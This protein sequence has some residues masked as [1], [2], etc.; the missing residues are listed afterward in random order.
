MND[1][2]L[3][4]VNDLVALSGD[5]NAARTAAEM[6]EIGLLRAKLAAAEADERLATALVTAQAA[7]PATCTNETQR[8]A[9]AIAATAEQAV[10]ASQCR[11]AQVE[12][13]CARVT[14]QAALRRVEDQR[15]TLE[16]VVA[17][18]G[19]APE[20]IPALP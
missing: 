1:N 13:E 12:A 8:R 17:V 2:K 11:A 16:Q 14:A 10:A 15:R 6:A 9:Y 18:A 19:L 20:M 3:R 4:L 5:L 7:A